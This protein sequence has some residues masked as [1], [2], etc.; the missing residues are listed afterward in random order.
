MGKKRKRLARIDTNQ[1][2]EDRRQSL[3]E[4]VVASHFAFT[5]DEERAFKH[6]ERRQA[7]RRKDDVRRR[8]LTIGQ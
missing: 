6:F 8:L 3:D 2:R 1:R 5:R 7:L 4:D